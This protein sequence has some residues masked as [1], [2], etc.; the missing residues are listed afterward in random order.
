MAFFTELG[1]LAVPADFSRL[2]ARARAR[3]V[4]QEPL[5]AKTMSLLKG[6]TVAIEPWEDLVAWADPAA[7]WDPE[8][9]L[10]AYSAYTTGLDRLDARFIASP[11]A[12]QRI[13]VWRFSEGFD[14]RDFFMDPPATTE[15]IFCH[16]SQLALQGPWQVLRRIRN[17]CGAPVE[18]GKVRTEFGEPVKVP[19]ARGDM[20]VAS[21][22]F[23]LPLLSKLA[24]V[25]LKPPFTYLTTWGTS[26]TPF[27]YR[28]VT[29][30]AADLHVLATPP[31]LGYTGRFAPASLSQ[32]E[33]SG[34]GWPSGK[35]SLTVVF[36][37]IPMYP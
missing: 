3:I 24:D 9:V 14:D 21:F 2:Q 20:V 26:G 25:L 34:G 11:K 35:G 31:A 15:A 5:V 13:L 19:P 8:P 1:D 33:L 17:R 29:G 30:T 22:Q 36:W 6:H 37:G 18:L 16:Y 27:T 23:G 10:Q 7:R 32:V 4:A 12:P 28:F